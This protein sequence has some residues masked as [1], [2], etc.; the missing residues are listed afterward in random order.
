MPQ[1]EFQDTSIPGLTL[2]KPFLVS[3]ARGYLSK[4]FET[5]IFNSRGISLMVTEEL[6]SRSKKDT[7]RGLHFQQR[8]SQDKLVRVLWGEVYDVAVDIRPS[9]PTFGKW[10]GFYL[11]AKNRQMLYLPKGF[12][13]GFYVCSEQAI[14]HYL[15]GD[16][17]DPDNESGILWNDPELAIHWP[18]EENIAPILSSRDQSF[19][20]F[21]DFRRSIGRA[22]K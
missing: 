20:S 11:S 5:S 12:A 16:Q 2:I 22:V 10:Q 14:L 17:Y 4:S 9:S 8:H 13:H 19:Q 7:L 1:F 6:E 15:C 21:A 3:D 18:V